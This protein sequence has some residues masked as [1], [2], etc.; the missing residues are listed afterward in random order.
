MPH[1]EGIRC[2]FVFSF[3]LFSSSF[4]LVWGCKSIHSSVNCFNKSCSGCKL[5]SSF[6]PMTLSSFVEIFVY[7]LSTLLF[8]S[9]NHIQKNRLS[10]VLQEELYGLQG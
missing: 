6:P 8:R 2:E 4:K 3:V 7:I 1:Q 5:S 10:I 9:C